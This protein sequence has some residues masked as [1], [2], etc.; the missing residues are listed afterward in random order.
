MSL[1]SILP[2]WQPWSLLLAALIN[3]LTLALMGIDKLRA[4]TRRGRRI[5]ERTLWLAALLGG[6]PGAWTGMVLFRHKTRHPSMGP[7]F[8]LLA[9]L[10]GLVYVL[11]ATQGGHLAPL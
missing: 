11:I 5:R 2:P 1:Y 3:A 9:I 4:Q 10:Q 7:M 8:A 6:G